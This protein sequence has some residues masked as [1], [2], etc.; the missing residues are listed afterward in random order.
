MLS[1][2]IRTVSPQFLRSAD[3]CSLRSSWQFELSGWRNSIFLMEDLE[4]AMYNVDWISDNISGFVVVCCSSVPTWPI[5][6][7]IFLRDHQ[8][9]L[10]TVDLIRQDLPRF[11][12]K[13]ILKKV[14]K[15]IRHRIHW[16]FFN[17][18]IESHRLLQWQYVPHQC[19][20][21][22]TAKTFEIFPKRKPTDGGAGRDPAA[23][24]EQHTGCHS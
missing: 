19:V 22:N 18:R 24:V 14:P 9:L 8:F 13:F 10:S 11:V 16:A 23:A 3:F 15:N 7:I 21:A 17:C 5:R 20:E 1:E 6:L 4:E 2:E 12:V